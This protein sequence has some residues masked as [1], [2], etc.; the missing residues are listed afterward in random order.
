MPSARLL[1]LVS[2]PAVALML[3]CS[4][5]PR[6][7]T[8]TADR[9]PAPAP[10]TAPRGT[11]TTPG[12]PWSAPV[13]TGTGPVVT[14]PSPM[15]VAP[16]PVA[17]TAPRPLPSSG[18]GFS[19]AGSL[20]AAQETARAQGKLIFLES[21]RDACGNCQYLKN[22][23]I[24]SSSVSG[25]LG[26][27]SVGYYD[28]CDRTPYSDAFN[29]LQANVVGAGTLPL[30]GWVTPDLRWV[31]G[32]WGRRDA[33]QFL[34]EI[35]TARS[36][37]SRMAQ[38]ARPA[39]SLELGLLPATGSLPD[40]ELADVS[41]ELADDGMIE[42]TPAAM[43]D[44]TAEAPRLA[45]ATPPSPAPVVETAAAPALP[46]AELAGPDPVATVPAT[47]PATPIF[48]SVNPRTVA[49]ASPAA[50]VETSTPAAVDARSWVRE[51]LRRAAAAL[52]ERHY[53][54]ARVILAGVRT[55]ATGLPEA[56]EAD[57]GEVAIYNLRK[58]EKARAS[59]DAD[60]LRAAAQRDLKDTVW[61]SLFA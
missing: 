58:I 37:Y 39:S 44:P 55:K 20:R 4:N 26:S 13:Y 30:A 36:V 61:V 33:S 17:P 48:A 40:A 11:T 60:R 2:L 47:A 23:V 57:K 27:M 3:G 54:E 45:A 21:G 53:I 22:D 29:I 12:R 49:V 38:E 46:T 42:T 19:W 15:A 5:K 35:T 59:A 9:P 18:A 24:P 41:A 7:V 34:A 16:P 32:F 14:S 1:A 8:Y 56:R 28:D 51:E 6:P 52:A 50:T 10:M 31:H 25:Q 43:L